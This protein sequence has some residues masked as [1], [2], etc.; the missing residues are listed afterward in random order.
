M[1]NGGWNGLLFLWKKIGNDIQPPPSFPLSFVWGSLQNGFCP[2]PI[3]SIILII[4]AWEIFRHN[5]GYSLTFGDWKHPK[6][7]FWIFFV[8]PSFWQYILCKNKD[9]L[10]LWILNFLGFFEVLYLQILEI[11]KKIAI[12][13]YHFSIGSSQY[14][15]TPRQFYFHDLFRVD[16]G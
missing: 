13:F 8:P 9:N 1:P 11:F 5:L 16:F 4:L 3:H 6:L 10:S 2:L 7:L 12:T 14:R 15:T